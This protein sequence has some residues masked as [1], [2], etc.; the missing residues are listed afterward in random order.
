[1][2]NTD[3]APIE[4]T[5][6][7]DPIAAVS[8]DEIDK[9]DLLVTAAEEPAVAEIQSTGVPPPPHPASSPPAPAAAPKPVAAATTTK[10]K[11]SAVEGA[12]KEVQN[13]IEH[14]ELDEN[15]SSALQKVFK[16]N[17]ALKEKVCIAGF[18]RALLF[19][20]YVLL[21]MIFHVLS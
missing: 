4:V 11:P 18:C 7:A 2:D 16:E 1:M 12:K 9:N 8:D 13:M 5:A 10:S 15:D 6:D 14:H 19:P 17:E 20:R 21:W 3:A